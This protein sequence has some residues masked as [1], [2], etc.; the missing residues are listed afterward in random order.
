MDNDQERQVSFKYE[1]LPNFC[2]W[3]GRVDHGDKDCAIW[4]ANPDSLNQSDQQFGPWMRASVDNGSRRT[5]V[6]VDGHTAENHDSTESNTHPPEN[7]V[8][9]Q[10]P[11]DF[12]ENYVS[13]MDPS[14]RDHILPSN[15]DH[16]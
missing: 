1:R 14:E 9:P 4:L 6:T 10:E 3:C 2:Y 11:M 7:E 12:Q 5:A 16:I 13:P 15:F 8:Q